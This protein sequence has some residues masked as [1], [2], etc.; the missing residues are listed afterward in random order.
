MNSIAINRIFI[1]ISGIVISIL[2]VSCLTSLQPLTTYETVTKENRAPGIWESNNGFVNVEEMTKSELFNDI[3]K[4]I[5]IRGTGS[6]K[7]LSNKDKEDSIWYSK[8]YMA[9]IKKDRAYY[10]YAAGFTHIGDDIYMDLFPLV[11]EDS[12]NLGKAYYPLNHIDYVPTFSIAKAEFTGNN[13]LVLKFLN[14]EFI[15]EQLKKG[16]MLIRHEEDKLFGSFLVTASTYDM[17]QFLAKYGHD[18]RLYS[19][20]NTITLT[21]KRS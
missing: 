5:E 16:N 9:V 10:C 6:N 4:S 17:T 1:I 13:T 14:G 19:Q 20:K 11:L 2:P 7:P 21:R 15:K 18:E 8:A 12:A 3:K